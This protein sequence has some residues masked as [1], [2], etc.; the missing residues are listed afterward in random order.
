MEIKIDRS[1][2]FSFVERYVDYILANPLT[3]ESIFYSANLNNLE[4]LNDT[5]FE[6][7]EQLMFNMFWLGVKVVTES[8][9][10]KLNLEN[11]ILNIPYRNNF[12]KYDGDAKTLNLNTEIK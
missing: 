6:T 9:Y 1:L 8:P 12:L 5:Q 2:K 11:E 10:I 7:L 4:N 3:Q